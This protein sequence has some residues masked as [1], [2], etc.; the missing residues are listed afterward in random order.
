MTVSQIIKYGLWAFIAIFGLSFLLGATTTVHQG[1]VGIYLLAGKANSQ[2]LEPGF[3]LKAPFIADVQQMPVTT[4]RYDSGDLALRSHDGQHVTARVVATGH[5]NPA[6]AVKLYSKFQSVDPDRITSVLV[7]PVVSGLSGST[8][9]HY[10][11][12]DLVSKR[13]DLRK[14]TA[15]D[16]KKQLAL[17]GIELEDLNIVAFNF[18]KEYNDNIERKMGVEQARLT[19]KLTLD[20]ETIQSQV[21]VVQSKAQ[22]EAAIAT[23]QGEAEST[24]LRAEA[25][26]KAIKVKNEALNNASPNFVSYLYA[27]KWDGQLPNVS[28]VQNPLLNLPAP[29][30]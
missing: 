27:T 28:G 18:S 25:E 23:A 6:F 5:I 19:A 14:E 24:R 26:A 22:A 29:R 4:F 1:N 30:Q 13:D 8:F 2:Y 12:D 11:V 3:H 7:G 21:Q 9:A 16:V 17:D 10:N 20:K 15:N